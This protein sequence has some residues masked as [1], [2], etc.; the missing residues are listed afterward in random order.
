MEAE[1]GGRIVRLPTPKD[2]DYSFEL[3]FHGPA[4]GGS[5]GREIVALLL[6]RPRD[7]V[8]WTNRFE[9]ESFY[10]GRSGN[11]QEA[12]EGLAEAFD[13]TVLRL[14]RLP[15]RIIQKRGLLNW[16]FALEARMPDGSWSQQSSCYVLRLG[17]RVP[18]VRGRERVYTAPAMAPLH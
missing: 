17:F 4:S 2:A 10:R 12:L 16:N 11:W 14:V 1:H 15:T 9:P 8:F 6:G 3:W 5:G 7:E 18:P 13:E